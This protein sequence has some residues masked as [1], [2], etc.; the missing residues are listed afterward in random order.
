MKVAKTTTRDTSSSVVQWIV[1]N[2]TMQYKKQK[3]KYNKTLAQKHI[4]LHILN[5]I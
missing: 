1:G 2:K 4:L 5:I 3:Q